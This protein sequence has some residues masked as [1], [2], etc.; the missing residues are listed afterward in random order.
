M[1]RRSFLQAAATGA[2][3]AAG[4]ACAGPAVIYRPIE[5][6]AGKRTAGFRL[7]YAPHFGMFRHHAG[8][9]RSTS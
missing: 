6:N 8:D 2:A 3:G 9:D 5:S 7:K 1:H 4:L